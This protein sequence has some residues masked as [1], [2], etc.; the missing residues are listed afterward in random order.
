MSLP[1]DVSGSLST[2]FSHVYEV[3]TSEG[4]PVYIIGK[5]MLNT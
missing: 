1:V 3:R 2:V 5:P 4:I